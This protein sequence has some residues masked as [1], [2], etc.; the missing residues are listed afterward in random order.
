[1][2]LW[3]FAGLTLCSAEGILSVSVG[4]G[5]NCFSASCFYRLSSPRRFLL[6]FIFTTRDTRGVSYLVER[7]ITAAEAFLLEHILWTHLS[8]LVKHAKSSTACQ[9]QWIS[10]SFSVFKLLKMLSSS[11]KMKAQRNRNVCHQIDRLPPLALQTPMSLLHSSD[12]SGK[13]LVDDCRSI[14]WPLSPSLFPH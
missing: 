4:V 2:K 10:L 12:C 9:M 14:H 6:G 5:E 7:N 11:L 13:I 1:M 3:Y 8:F